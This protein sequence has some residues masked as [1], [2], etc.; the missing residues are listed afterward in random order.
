MALVKLKGSPNKPRH[1]PGK[2]TGRDKSRSSTEVG[3]KG[4]KGDVGGE[5]MGITS[6]S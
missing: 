1:E 6:T 4:S 3:W 2:G 5:A